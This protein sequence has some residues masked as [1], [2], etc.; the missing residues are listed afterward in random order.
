VILLLIVATTIV[1]SVGLLIWLGSREYRRTNAELKALYSLP[2]PDAQKWA[3]RLI[4]QGLFQCKPASTSMNNTNLPQSVADVLNLFDEIIRNEFWINRHALAETPARSG[5]IK[6]G[7]DAEFEEILV[8][9]GSND[10]FLSYGP[11]HGK[12]SLEQIPSL[13]HLL[14][15]VSGVPLENLV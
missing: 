5:F 8:R 14:I 10:I 6:I 2:I 4:D 12:E 9:E 3:L 7:S 11:Q 13:W 15:L 1:G